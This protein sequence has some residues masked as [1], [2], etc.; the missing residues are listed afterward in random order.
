MLQAVLTAELFTV[1]MVFA[2]IGS[3]FVVLP[4]IG[5]TF[6]SPRTRLTFAILVALIVAPAVEPVVPAL[7][8]DLPTTIGLLFIEILVGLFI[9]TATRLLFSALAI[10]GSFYSFMS[11]L[12][13]ALM[14]NPLM[15]DQGAL[16]SVFL[17]LLG[18]LLIFATDTHHLLLRAVVESYVMFE[19]GVYPMIGDMADVVT[20]TVTDAFR[21]GFQLA[22]PIVVVALMFYVLLGLLA[23]LMP[24]MQVFFIA[25][26]LQIL[27]GL[28][29]LMITLSGMMMWF[30]EEYHGFLAQFLPY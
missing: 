27:M 28:F 7:P 14:F 16:L 11:G 30:L 4:T 19:P 10:A 5:E 23:R 3:A 25:M 24:Q 26:P 15:S 20:R 2:R 22:A 1:L 17:S 29:L 18:L 8:P 6:I 12:A 21:I 13:S 9:G